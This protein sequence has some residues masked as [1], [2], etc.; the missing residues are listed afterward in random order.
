[1]PVVWLVVPAV[2]VLFSIAGVGE[3]VGNEDIDF[4]VVGAEGVA[5]LWFSILTWMWA[6]ARE[7][8]SGRAVEKDDVCE[9][10]Q[11][12]AWMDTDEEEGGE[13]G[14]LVEGDGKTEESA[15]G[16]ALEK[17]EDKFVDNVPFIFS[18][19]LNL[20]ISFLVNP[21]EKQHLNFLDIHAEHGLN[22]K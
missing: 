15:V 5:K 12:E 6:P 20:M 9:E 1:M 16:V 13:A 14:M 17:V 4:K 19:L 7:D 8:E 2:T 3:G 22:C 11:V 10:G 18:V 21:F